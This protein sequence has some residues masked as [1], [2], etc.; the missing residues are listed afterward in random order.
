MSLLDYLMA[1]DVESFNAERG[2][3][4]RIDLF[5]ADLAGAQL[6]GVDL[7]SVKLG[8][9]D[10]SKADLRDATLYRADLHGIDGTEL[11]LDRAL[12]PRVKLREAWLE[13]ADLSGAD[14]TKADLAEVVA[15]RSRAEGTR[16]GG[17]RLREIDAR[18]VSWPQVDLSDAKLHKANFTE[19]D[20]SGADLSG[21]SGAEAVFDKARLDGSIARAVR[22][23]EASLVGASLSQ[24]QWPRADLSGADLSGADLQFAD[25][26]GANL[27]GA[28]LQGASLRGAVLADAVL[29]GVDLSGLD[30]SGVDL[31]GVDAGVLGLSEEQQQGLLAVGARI[32]ESAPLRFHAPAAASSGTAVGML[33]LNT[34]G[35]EPESIPGTGEEE[36]EPPRSLRWAIAEA[37]E[38]QHGAIPLPARSIKARALA[39]A[40]DGFTA[41]L[42][43]ERPGGTRLIRYP[44]SREGE[45]G[46]PQAQ[47]LGYRAAVPPRVAVDEDGGLWMWC[48]AR[49]GP[50]LVVHHF[51]R[52]EPEEPPH[53]VHSER[54]ATA[55]G[56]LGR[57]QPV[58]ACKGGV[59]MPVSRRGAHA[60]TR[61]PGPSEGGRLLTGMP[62]GE[63]ALVA[64]VRPADSRN[65][66][67]V[68]CAR[69]GERGAPEVQVLSRGGVIG[70]LDLVVDGER[71]WVAWVVSDGPLG[72]TTVHLAELPEASV[73]KLPVP[74][75]VHDVRLTVSR[76]GEPPR[77]VCTT[78]EEGVVVV[79][80]RGRLIGRHGS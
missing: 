65:P 16:L 33:W 67:G 19:A 17:A 13:D 46:Q 80:V 39:P 3:R 57:Y 37:G 15:I 62:M 66:G 52:P 64:W 49:R 72:A 8:K 43:V 51:P 38:I 7:A 21:A 24:G 56:F 34:D 55:R 4:Q 28:C 70:T 27:S 31:S 45:L 61:L 42:L 41:L 54:V 71:A 77:L 78:L 76:L 6:R 5:A 26:T 25:L 20:L 35:E 23:P 11:R 9:A 75:D 12:G 47:P 74:G 10:L 69:L 1:G 22:L 29:D 32:D 48:L 53:P 2:Q 63:G 30:L 68:R 36:S 59:V 60:P 50:T 40:P 44:L 18:E 14:L 58:L 79:D 73:R